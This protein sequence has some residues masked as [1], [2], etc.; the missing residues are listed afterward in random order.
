[1]KKII[2]VLSLI[3]SGCAIGPGYYPSYYVPRPVNTYAYP[4]GNNYQNYDHPT[5][6]YPTYGMGHIHRHWR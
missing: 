5:Y 4:Y 1:M 6:G 2:I 3:I